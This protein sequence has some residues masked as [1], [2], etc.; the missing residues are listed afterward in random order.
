MLESSFSALFVV[1]DECGG[2]AVVWEECAVL[3][4]TR[5]KSDCFVVASR[6]EHGEIPG[7]EGHS[8]RAFASEKRRWKAE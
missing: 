4:G 5:E 3:S 8:L 1:G 7:G 2:V 6:V